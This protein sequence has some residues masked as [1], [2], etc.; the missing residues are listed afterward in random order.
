V[1]HIFEY[2][3][4]ISVTPEHQLIRPDAGKES[5]NLPPVQFIFCLK[6]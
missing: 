1:A 4:Q 2:S 6:Q 3:S 5:E